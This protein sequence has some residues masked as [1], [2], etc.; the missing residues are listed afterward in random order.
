MIPRSI[1]DRGLKKVSISFASP[2]T[3][4]KEEYERLSLQPATVKANEDLLILFSFLS[5]SLSL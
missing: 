4:D 1:L 3:S 5:P 2:V